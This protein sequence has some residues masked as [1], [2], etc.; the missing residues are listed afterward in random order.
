MED[1]KIGDTTL[2][3]DSDSLKLVTITERDN[4]VII[5]NIDCATFYPFSNKSANTFTCVASETFREYVYFEDGKESVLR[6]EQPLYLAVTQHGHRVFD[7]EG[8][9]HYV[10]KGWRSIR[11]KVHLGQPNF[12]K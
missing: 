10:A 4:G 11:W 3:V 2:S 6:I 1:F 5:K 9:S 8:V 12:V 7:A